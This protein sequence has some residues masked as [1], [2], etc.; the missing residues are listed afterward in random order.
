M[1]ENEINTLVVRKPCFGLP[2][3]CTQC[4][5]A[6]LYLK[7]AQFSFQLDFHLNYPDSD[8]IPYFELGDY[9]AYNNE[10]GGLIECLKR[11]VGGVDL[12]SGISSLPDWIQTKA[13]LTTWLADAL[14][15]EL[16]VGSEGYSSSPAYTIYYSDLPW[17]LGK[18]LFWRKACWIKQKHGITNEN[19]ELKKE[20]IYRRANSAYGAL[21]TWLGEQSYLFENRPSSLD[22]IFLA[23][24]LV[25]LQALPESSVLRSKLLEHAN[26]VRFVQQCKTE[27]IDA[28]P[29]P[30]YVRQ[31]HTAGSSSTSRSR[32]T[33]SSKTK[34]KPKREKTEEE[35]T[36]K[37]RSKYFV[38][39]QL[40]AV[41]VFLTIMTSFDDAAVDLDD[42]DGS[43]GYDE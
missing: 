34:S 43:Y 39:A 25:T 21:S 41:V 33:S 26:L 30:T 31:F 12:D 37:R 35:K 4:L 32:S 9:V 19:A 20:E 13:M 36:F 38:A 23:H 2:T 10:K 17:P 27:L 22:A 7:F 24:G 40:V 16:W 14:D 18:V 29:T 1:A 6:Y 8:Q 3:G 28:S 15:Y 5:S 11:D 42:A